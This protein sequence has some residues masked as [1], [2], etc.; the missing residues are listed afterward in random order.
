MWSTCIQHIEWKLQNYGVLL[1][2]FAF[3]SLLSLCIGEQNVKI[4]VK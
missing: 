3:F 2:S 4:Q 1:E